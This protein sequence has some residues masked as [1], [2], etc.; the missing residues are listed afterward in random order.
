MKDLKLKGKVTVVTEKE[1]LKREEE[2]KETNFK[3]R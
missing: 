1:N 3:M 2:L